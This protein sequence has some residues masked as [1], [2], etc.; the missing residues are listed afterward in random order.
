MVFGSKISR[1]AVRHFV[2][3]FCQTCRYFSSDLTLTISVNIY[4]YYKI[5]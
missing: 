1:A 4:N 2:K 3:A 5:D